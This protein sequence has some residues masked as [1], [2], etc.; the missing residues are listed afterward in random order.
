MTD[1]LPSLPQSASRV[2][3]SSDPSDFV[4][5]GVMGKIVN[6][7]ALPMFRDEAQGRRKKIKIRQD[8]ILSKKP[9]QPVNGPGAQG[10]LSGVS[11]FT[12]FVM[13]NVGKQNTMREQDARD[14]ILKFA[15]KAKT[16]MQL[17]GRAYK[18]TAPV[19]ALQ[20]KTLEQEIEEAERLEREILK[21]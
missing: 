20:A 13:A 17:V 14:E 2:K 11:G 16:G 5:P 1:F 9:E 6:P 18:T 21:K 8:P 7:H 10:R 4:S 3:R 15:E 19:Q 12:Q